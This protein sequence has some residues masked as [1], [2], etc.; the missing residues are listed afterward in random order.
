[1]ANALAPV[2]TAEFAD[3]V[4]EEDECVVL[5]WSR[6]DGIV[7]CRVCLY[8]FF[9]QTARMER[10]LETATVKPASAIPCGRSMFHCECLSRIDA[11]L[12]GIKE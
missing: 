12:S 9:E 2:R 1:V 4:F 11:C 6:G 10:F 3:G 5:K 7:V 8:A